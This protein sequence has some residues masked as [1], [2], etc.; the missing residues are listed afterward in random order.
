MK[1]RP[2]TLNMVERA[3][4]AQEWRGTVPAARIHILIGDGGVHMVNQA[5]KVLFVVLG[6]AL[7]MQMDPDRP[8]LRIIRASVNALETQAEND[9]V[10][11]VHRAAI[12]SGLEACV[13][14]LPEIPH[15]V[16]VRSACD[17]HLKLKNGHAMASDFKERL[18]R[19]VA[20]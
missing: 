7:E 9:E 11:P 2:K 19:L 5:G 6:A 4:I 18:G 16:I 10:N 3:V 8:E 17:L 20:A 13:R 12:S 1:P 15:P 14:L